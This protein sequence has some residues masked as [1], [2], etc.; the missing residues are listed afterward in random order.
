LV[1][2][3]LVQ[4]PLDRHVRLAPDASIHLAEGANSDAG[5]QHNL[6]WLDL[7]LLQ[8][9]QHDACSSGREREGGS[10]RGKG[11]LSEVLRQQQQRQ[12]ALIPGLRAVSQ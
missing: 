2:D 6:I 4:Q 11:C 9:L 3:L 1:R 7:P 8:A 12:C 10:E 5:P